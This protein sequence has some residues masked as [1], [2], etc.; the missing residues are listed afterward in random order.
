MDHQQGTAALSEKVCEIKGKGKKP[1]V[2]WKIVDKVPN[3]W[4]AYN[5]PAEV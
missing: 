4:D 1:K 2:E 5:M 3:L